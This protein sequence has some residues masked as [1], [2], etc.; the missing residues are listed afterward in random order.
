MQEQTEKVADIFKDLW[1]TVMAQDD[2]TPGDISSCTIVEW[3][4]RVKIDFVNLSKENQELKEALVTKSPLPDPAIIYAE[5][6]IEKQKQATGMQETL[7]TTVKE[8][9]HLLKH[10]HECSTS[11]TM[12]A[13]PISTQL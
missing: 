6:V 5:K 3:S 11:L 8:A 2:K 13:Q 7:G 1:P 12:K 10:F 9:Y 4:I